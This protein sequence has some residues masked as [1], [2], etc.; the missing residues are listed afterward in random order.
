[1]QAI[2]PR[3]STVEA[4]RASNHRRHAQ[5]KHPVSPLSKK[6]VKT[7]E[8]TNDSC[9]EAHGVDDDA[10]TTLFHPLVIVRTPDWTMIP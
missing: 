5:I 8:D 3:V 7:G 9:A 10:P 4:R 6:K 2:D 1:M